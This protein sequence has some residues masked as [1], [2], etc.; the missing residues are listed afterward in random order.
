M[1][2]IVSELP[3]MTNK[4]NLIARI[5]DLTRDG[6]LD[7]VVDLRDESDRHGMRIV[8]ELSKNADP[9]KILS[10]LYKKTPMQGTFSFNMLALVNG[11]PQKLSLK[12]ALKVYI[13]HRLEVIRRRSEFELRK[14]EE[15]LHILK[16]LRIA[17]MNLD[18]VI[19]I[20]RS[21]RNS[22]TASTKL[23]KR[24]NLDEIQA[25]A[26][27]DMPLRRLAS[28]ERK[29]IEEEFDEISNR[30]KELKLLLKSPKKMRQ[31]VID[32]LEEVKAKFSDPRRTQ[33]IKLGEGSLVS[34]LLTQ[35]DL[36]PEENFWISYTNDGR[37]SRS[38]DDKSFRMSGTNAS[39][40]VIRTSSHQTVILVTSEGL[41]AA[42]HS[43]A[44][45]VQ[46]SHD[47][48]VKISTI[49]PLHEN[50]LIV[51][52]FSVP[53]DT[54]ELPETSI[55]SISR[56]GMVKKSSI[57]DLPSP[58]ASSFTLAKV[59]D[60][61]ELYCTLLVRPAED[62]L[63]STANGMSIR[64]CEDQVRSMGLV[65]AGVNGIKLKNDDFVVGASA[66]H[67]NEQIILLT[68]TGLGKRVLEKEFP[69]QGRY[70]QGVIAWRLADGD[71]VVLQLTGK[72]TDRAICHFEKSASKFVKISDAP[73]RT[74]A[75]NGKKV[76]DLKSRDEI[77]GFTRI[78]DMVD[79]WS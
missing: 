11:G 37:I 49:S 76:F 74:R 31:L 15:R 9:E 27:L 30:I 41:A 46:S 29:K 20:I 4:S 53:L 52:L 56:Q 21:S 77:I 22:E 1:R 33:I 5:A 44:I 6:I 16:A 39:W 3:Y 34:E 79:Y 50:D 57:A 17:L 72:L 35:S 68:K 43:M 8:I 19:N 24:F 25:T 45:P 28:L 54:S 71:K 42:I 66:L 70:G 75:A 55:I 47:E 63:I 67:P 61:D 12:H 51:G 36:M 23:M 73:S 26:I 18:E 7:G 58:S 48:G 65:A 14:K 69:V 64:F 60:G 2:I 32:E 10:L 13:E 78:E 40:N 59:N 38:A 62:L